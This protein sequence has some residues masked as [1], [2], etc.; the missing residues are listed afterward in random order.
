MCFGI[1]KKAPIEI[2]DDGQRMRSLF[3]NRTT[4]NFLSLSEAA[5]NPET[6]ISS[7]LVIQFQLQISTFRHSVTDRRTEIIQPSTRYPGHTPRGRPDRTYRQL[8]WIIGL[9][10]SWIVVILVSRWLNFGIRHITGSSNSTS[11]LN[12]W[13]SISYLQRF[14][15]FI[16][17]PFKNKQTKTG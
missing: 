11:V 10:H 3:N 4:S 5:T 12:L 15:I 8:N 9:S 1:F 14:S 16:G 2:V 7:G 17:L 6:A 13:S